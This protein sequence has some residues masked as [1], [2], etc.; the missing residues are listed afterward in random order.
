MKRT[1][2]LLL[3]LSLALPVAAERRRAVLPVAPPCAEAVIAAP[4]FTNDI[5]TDAEFVY[6][7]DEFGG[8]YRLPK[9]GGSEATRL[10]QMT[11]GTQVLSIVVDD[12]A[13]YFTT[14]N[15]DG[16][17]ASVY[18][19]PKGGGSP[20]QLASGVVTPSDLA[21]DDNF[22]FWNSLG[23]PSG[24][25][26]LP[27]GKIERI[28]KDGSNRTTLASALSFP[29]S[30]ALDGNNVL[31]GETGIATGDTSAGLRSV[32]KNGG[33]VTTLRDNV[34]VL[35]IAATASNIYIGVVNQFSGS[36]AVI[37]KSTNT[38]SILA[39]DAGGLP[40]MF[41][42]FDNQLYY[43]VISDI[44]GIGVVPLSGGDP[45]II[46]TGAFSTVEFAVDGCALFYD[47]VDND[48]GRGEIRRTP[49]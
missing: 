15:T 31:F 25:Q 6:F 40:V 10:V 28:G 7:T 42:I 22:L 14:A 27:D 49:R 16:F 39:S 8:L 26:F 17:L 35:A 19:V 38:P 12:R 46:K 21:G 1:A 45:R 33:A 24:D 30:F 48:S 36:I 47:P 18:S 32:P 41:H 23:T 20:T 13:I 44:D 37:S 34:P 3:A 43:Y 11:D 2:T 5:V 4:F 29:I 9:R